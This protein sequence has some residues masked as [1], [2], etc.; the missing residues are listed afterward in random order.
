MELRHDL[1]HDPRVQ[2]RSKRPRGPRQHG[3]PIDKAMHVVCD[4][5]TKFPAMLGKYLKE[6]HESRVCFHRN[7]RAIGNCRGKTRP[8][9]VVPRRSRTAAQILTLSL[10]EGETCST[11]PFKKCFL[12]R[13][14]QL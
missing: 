10:K 9:C 1:L 4:P 11:W 2:R 12:D 14:A 5:K 13:L 3:M 8:K 6:L 7:R